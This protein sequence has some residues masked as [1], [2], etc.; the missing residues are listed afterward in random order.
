MIPET[1]DMCPPVSPSTKLKACPMLA[2]KNAEGKT[3]SYTGP[4]CE[5]VCK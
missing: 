5:V 1:S 3:C 4:N 2:F